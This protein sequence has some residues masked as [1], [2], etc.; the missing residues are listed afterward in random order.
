MVVGRDVD[1]MLT[2]E[3]MPG[4]FEANHG[5]TLVA[6]RGVRVKGSIQGPR[7]RRTQLRRMFRKG[8]TKKR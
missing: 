7:K 1:F 2:R 3:M 6:K 5:R 4:D 8:K